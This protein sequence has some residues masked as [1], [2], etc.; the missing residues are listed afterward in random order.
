MTDLFLGKTDLRIYILMGTENYNQWKGQIETNISRD[1]LLL[2]VVQKGPLKFLDK[3]DKVKDV[4]ALTLDEFTKL[5]YNGKARSSLIMGLKQPEYDKVSSPKLAKEIQDALQTYH[6][7]SK[8]LK[9]VNLG[10][11]MNDF[12]NFKLKECE[13]IKE[14]RVRF[15]VTINTL[16]R[17]GKKIA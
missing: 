11:L 9:K 15:Q 6:E 12:G 8:S 3:D 10:S 5:G 17:S 2:R 4:D 14:A 7:G 16:Q 1:P 13:T